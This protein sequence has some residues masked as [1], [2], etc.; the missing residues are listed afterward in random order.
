MIELIVFYFFIGVIALSSFALFFTK[1]VIHNAAYL[2]FSL[3]SVAGLFVLSGADFIA[4]TQVMVYIGGVLVLLLFGVMYTKNSIDHEMDSGSKRSLVGFSF[5]AILFGILA[6]GILEEGI[7][8]DY[9]I[10]NEGVTSNLGVS[11][12]TDQI[13][14]F[15][16][17][18]ILL[19]VVLIG[20]VFVAGKSDKSL[21]NH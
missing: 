12:M 8:R 19:L 21:D 14:A 20:A 11:F 6:F 9:T 13:F 5:G 10:N 15:E 18:A 16:L 4:I 3:L 7:D 17:T 1:N 2:L